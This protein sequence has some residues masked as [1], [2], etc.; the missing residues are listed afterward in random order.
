MATDTYTTKDKLLLMGGERTLS[1]ALQDSSWNVHQAL[2]NK[3]DDNLEEQ[4]HAN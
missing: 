4:T 1:E 2:T 3:S